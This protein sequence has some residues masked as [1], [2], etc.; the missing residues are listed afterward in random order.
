MPAT[1]VLLADGS[2]KPIKLVK[3]GD[4]VRATDER[5]GEV[6]SREI[7]ATITGWGVKNLV[8]ITTDKAGV[9][10]ATD[11]HP[12][13]DPGKQKW[14]DAEDLTV[15]SMLQTFTGDR[16]RVSSVRKFASI[17]RVYNLTVEGV[18]TYFVFAGDAAIL[19]HNANEGTVCDLTLGPA[20]K[21]QKAEGVSAER[22]DT[23][24]AHEQKMVNEYG[25]RNGCAA[26]GADESGYSDGHW[27]GDHNPPN[28]LAPEGPWTLYP[29]C[30]ACSRQQGG[31]V[32]TLIKEYYQF[33]VVTVKQ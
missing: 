4:Q 9:V 11:E 2:Q 14:V 20:L 29:H 30:K 26:C 28:K 19:V 31:I 10:T 32:R 8:E 17:E 27:T 13:W 21:G 5:T 6:S 3:V 33:P 12:F 25:D 18:H 15:G 22:G 7:V 16:V 23:V 1:R 24:L